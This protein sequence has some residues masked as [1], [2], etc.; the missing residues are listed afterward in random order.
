[1]NGGSYG[2]PG[3]EGRFGE[4]SG[5]IEGDNGKKENRLE[6]VLVFGPTF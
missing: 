2:P 1:M 4:S 3:V 6:S 5:G